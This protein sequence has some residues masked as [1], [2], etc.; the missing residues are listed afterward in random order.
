V[1]GS[2]CFCQRHASY[3]RGSASMAISICAC[4]LP[5]ACWQIPDPGQTTPGPWKRMRHESTEHH[6]RHRQHS[7][8]S[9]LS[10]T[11]TCAPASEHAMRFRT[12]IGS[13]VTRTALL[14]VCPVDLKGWLVDC[15]RAPK[16]NTHLAKNV[17]DPLISVKSKRAWFPPSRNHCAEHDHKT[18]RL[19]TP[20]LHQTDTPFSPIGQSHWLLGQIQL[21]LPHGP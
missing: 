19:L 15:V 18:G 8:P 12:R 7:Q 10:L 16:G 11:G 1:G 21:S 3:S 2:P 14:H 13:R 20:H 4:I 5:K 6:P 9:R 17:H